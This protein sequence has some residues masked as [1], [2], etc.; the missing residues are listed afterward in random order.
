MLWLIPV[1]FNPLGNNVFS[2]FRV[3]LLS[4]WLLGI[5]ILWVI[6]V[7]KNDKKIELTSKGCLFALVSCVFF[8]L[9][10]YFSETTGASLLGAEDRMQGVLTYLMYFGLCFF[11][12]QYRKLLDKKFFLVG[13]AVFFLVS[14]HAI[15][16]KFGILRFSEEMYGVYSERVYSTVGHPNFLGQLLVSI[17]LIGYYLYGE[18]RNKFWRFLIVFCGFINVL[19]LVFTENRASW[20]ALLFVSSLIVL[21]EFDIKFKY[22]VGILS[23]AGAV[24]LG[25]ILLMAPSLRSLGTRMILWETSFPLVFDSVLIGHGLESF[26]SVYQVYASVDLLNFEPIYSVA[27]RSHNFLLD[28][29]IEGGLF[30]L[31]LVG[32][33]LF[34]GISAKTNKFKYIWLVSF[35]PWMLSFPLVEHWIFSILFFVV[36]FKDFDPKIKINVS[37][38]VISSFLVG[39]VLIGFLGNAYFYYGRLVNDFNYSLGNYMISNDSDSDD[40]L[41]VE[42]VLGSLENGELN[43]EYNVRFINFVIGLS[44]SIEEK[45]FKNQ[46]DN[47]FMNLVNLRGEDFFY[48]FLK[49]QY[50]TAF[51]D[52][53]KAKEYYE[54]S[55][56]KSNYNLKVL[57]EYIVMNYYADNCAEVVDNYDIYMERVPETWKLVLEDPESDELRIFMK[58]INSTDFW[59]L[60]E[61]ATVCNEVLDRSDEVEYYNIYLQKKPKS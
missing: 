30:G 54:S 40:S 56:E 5:F 7:Y 46:I 14:L 28:V 24:F 57:R 53:E 55:L 6:D 48:D 13:F 31:L 17:I 26:K 50:F 61:F 39:M 12:F 19:A 45:D 11:L 23:L 9:N 34:K 44:E 38:S 16:Q 22:K 37:N 18:F 60:M 33:Y 59:N 36:I 29:L 35:L 20:L 2:L 4:F 49:G 25:L 42:L 43:Y 52:F 58:N 10:V 32:Y 1:V 47:A 41:G 8:A 21:D 27:G 3:A 15:L 51:G